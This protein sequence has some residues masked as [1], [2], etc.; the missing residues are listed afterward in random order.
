MIS[1]STRAQSGERD[2]SSAGPWAISLGQKGG[3]F[4]GRRLQ[5]RGPAERM[6]RTLPTQVLAVPVPVLCHRF[7][8]RA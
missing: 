7:A 8:G 1:V 4:M 5:G 2:C 3:H 6:Q